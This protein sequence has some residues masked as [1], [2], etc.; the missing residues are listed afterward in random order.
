MNPIYSFEQFTSP[1]LS[2]KRL[3]EELERRALRRS[4]TMLAAGGILILLCL[5]ALAVFSYPTAPLLSVLCF[6]YLWIAIT[7]GAVIIL[8]F[9]QRRRNPLWF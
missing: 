8:I 3:R 5:F 7:G 1:P 9:L 6:A 2:E 4:I